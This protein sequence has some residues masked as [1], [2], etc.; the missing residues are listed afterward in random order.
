MG[1]LTG[2]APAPTARM[3][4]QA[5]AARR[6]GGA[7]IPVLFVLLLLGCGGTSGTTTG[8]VGST[9]SAGATG[10]AG[11]GG[12]GGSTGG[13]GGQTGNAGTTGAGGS[14]A[15]T[16][17][18]ASEVSSKIPTVGIVTWS[19]TLA[20]VQSAR[21]DFGLATSHGMTAPVDLSQADDPTLP[22]LR[23]LLLGMKT[24]R[25]YHFRI[26]AAAAAGEC[27]SDD[28]TITTGPIANGLQ[29]P[30]VT[31]SNASTLAGGF[32]VTGQHA[33]N[34]GMSS[35]QAYIL[36]ADGD[37]VWWLAVTND[38]SGARMS[39]DGTHMWINS[40]N[41]PSG[42]AH[43]RRVAMDGS[44]NEDLSAQFTGANHQQ[45]VL[46][47][48]TVAFY[49]YGSN[50]CDDIK[51]RS[52]S[53]T[54]K[55]IVNSR[56]AHG[57]TGACHINNV[58]YSPDDQTL[59][60]SDLD[61]NVL[62]KISRTGT[63]VWVLNGL[64]ATGITNGFTGDTWVGGEHGIH[65]LGLDKLLIFNNNSKAPGGAT[66]TAP[67]AADGSLALEIKL[68]LTAKKATKTVVYKGSGTSFQ[69]DVMG[70]VQ[71]LSNGNTIIAFSTKGIIIEVDASGTMLQQLK[72][73][74][75]FGYIHKR[76]TLY[77]PSP[78]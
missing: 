66:T 52:P 46:P 8:P 71:R 51:E 19:T 55:T 62:T 76:A 57:G 44:T 2:V 21:I 31:T 28:Y 47:D 68:D 36:D 17:T 74:A 1:A 10:A 12:A 4:A 23:T 78:R 75:T 22:T 14:V 30:T 60:F 11:T 24:S 41:V 72:T 50:G 58:Q 73:T 77:G 5:R 49:G 70:D 38:V 56:T 27:R 42:S 18:V 40:A 37:Y 3:K 53:G 63:V 26:T 61:N 65:V 7:S 15:C 43:V 35:A 32:L 69:N 34:A 9:G 59:V 6:V 20:G 48:E 16:F 13:G 29:K 39:H 64:G 67:G 45:T 54:T 33:T 25:L